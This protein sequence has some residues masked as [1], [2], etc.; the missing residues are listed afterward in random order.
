MA[1]AAQSLSKQLKY[2]D[3]T[4]L[5]TQILKDI[6]RTIAAL[7]P[8]IGWLDRVPFRGTAAKLPSSNDSNFTNSLSLL[9]LPGQKNFDELRSIIMQLGLEMAT[10]AMRDRFSVKPVE[11]V[12]RIYLN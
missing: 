3:Q 9:V 8:L 2:S 4:K 10:M 1:S 12:S 6:T 11:T 5:E 7:K